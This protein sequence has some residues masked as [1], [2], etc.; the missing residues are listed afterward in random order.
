MRYISGYMLSVL[1][2]NQEPEAEEIVNILSSVGIEADINK[3]KE[4][5]LLLIKFT[6]YFLLGCS[7]Y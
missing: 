2:G 3:A 1:A 5:K 4:V 7:I 6:I